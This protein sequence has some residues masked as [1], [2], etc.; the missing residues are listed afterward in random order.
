MT[1]PTTA[2]SSAV[3]IVSSS[4]GTVQNDLMSSIGAAA[5]IALAVGGVILA[6]TLGWKLFKR[7]SK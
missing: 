5:P 2:V 7:F 1:D 6:I 4:L 3:D